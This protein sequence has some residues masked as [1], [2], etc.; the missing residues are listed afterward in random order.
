MAHKPATEK[1]VEQ[2]TSAV[3][4]K[5]PKGFL[6]FYRKTNGG[7]IESEEQYLVIW[8]VQELVKLNKL[9]STEEFAPEFFLFGSDGGGTAFA[10]EKKSGH[11]FEMPFIGM[12]RDEA[13]LRAKSFSEFLD[14]F[15]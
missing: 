3:K 10:I 13:Q 12:G 9:Y 1:Q 5:L 2:F 4:M 14:G 15:K 6:D 11:I 7:D 8:R